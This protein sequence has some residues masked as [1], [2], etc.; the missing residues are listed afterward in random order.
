MPSEGSFLPP[1]RTTLELS[2]LPSKSSVK[3]SLSFAVALLAVPFCLPPYLIPVLFP[4][5]IV[6]FYTIY[7]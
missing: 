6:A 3:A 4:I 7:T 5:S 1:Y 2:I